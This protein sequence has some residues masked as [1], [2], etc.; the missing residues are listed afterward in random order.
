MGGGVAAQL[1]L[2]AG[3]G[4]RA[5]RRGGSRRR[6]GRR[7]EPRP[8]AP[9]RA[10]GPSACSCALGGVAS[11]IDPGVCPPTTSPAAP[12]LALGLARCRGRASATDPMRRLPTTTAAHRPAR[13]DSSPRRRLP[14]RRPSRP[15]ASSPRSELVVKFEGESRG[16]AV[17]LAAG[18]RRAGERGG[19]AAQPRRRLRRAR[20]HRHRLRDRP[21][22]PSRCPTTRAPSPA[23]PKPSPRPAT[24]PQAVEL[25]ALGRRR[26]DQAA[27]LP[28]RHRRGRRLEQPRR[29]RPARRRRHHRRRPRHRR[30]LPRP[31]R[32]RPQPR[33]RLRSVRQ[34]ARLHRRRPA[35]A[36]RKRPRHP[37]RR[38]DRREDRQRGRADRTRLPGEADAGAGA[39]QA[40][41][42]RGDRHR[43]G[44]PLRR[45]PRRRR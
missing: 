39:R 26:D 15:L 34:G 21:R 8:G 11:A 12:V 10:P 43:P 5:R 23:P 35:A 29:S 17:A 40:R 1:A 45:R 13:A 36:G 3:G 33:L 30:R 16:H 32:L 44:H 14:R 38:H 18:R 24:G 19:T 6:S 41:P 28:G 2:V 22:P 31:R 37:R 25:P 27:D 42:R 9:A 4:E 7:R 20:L